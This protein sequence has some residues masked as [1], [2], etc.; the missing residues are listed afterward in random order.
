MSLGVWLTEIVFVSAICCL[1]L[2][3]LEIKKF[4]FIQ[5]RAIKIYRQNFS[6]IRK[7]SADPRGIIWPGPERDE[8]H[9]S[10]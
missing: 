8:R 6:F 2:H 5:R 9:K 3:K 1:H 4:D 10:D 7:L